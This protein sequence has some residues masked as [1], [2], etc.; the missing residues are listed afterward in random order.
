MDVLRT[1]VTSPLFFAKLKNM[2][3]FDKYGVCVPQILLPKNIDIKSWSVIACDQYTQDLNYWK[4]AAK[5]AGSKP[6]AL[7]LIYPEVYLE[8]ADKDERI[9]KIQQTMKQ[10][11]SDGVFADAQEECVYIE[12]K[13][14]YGRTRRGLVLAIDLDKYEWKPDS[15]A[16]IRATEATV[17]ERIPPRMKIRNGAA[18]EIPHIMLLAND[19]DD[20][21]IGGLGAGAKKNAPVYDGDLMQNSG[22]I[23]GWAV[24][25]EEAEKAMQDALEVLYKNGTD[26]NGDTFLFAVGDGNHSL[27]TAK[28]V[29]DANKDKL[30]ADSPVRY[31]LVEVVNIYDTGLTFEPIHRVL[32]KLD[33]VELL[34]T[35]AKELG[36]SIVD[37]SDEASLE[38]A[39]SDTGAQGA[40]YGFVYTQNNSTVYKMLDTKITDLAI[41]ALQPCLDKYMTSKG[42]A[43]TQIDYIHGSKD[44]VNLG[45][46]EGSTGILLPPVDKNSFFATINGR[47]P[48]PRKSFSMGEASEKRFYVEARRLF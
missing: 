14:E 12:R 2:K 35:V 28:A 3:T 15:K 48:L 20:K 38:K 13:T 21:L 47:G 41:A 16:L 9:Q 42:A 33:S 23:T 46:K 31:A 24:K 29:W 7:N 26:K 22:H 40:R 18:L 32:F 36:G 6:S 5:A 25:G 8:E 37:F 43:K 19:K 39:V 10:Y 34:N 44:V 30:P 1:K 17:P 27:A 45:K 4:E 11:L